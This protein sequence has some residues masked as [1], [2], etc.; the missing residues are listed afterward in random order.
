MRTTSKT[1][2]KPALAAA[3]AALLATTTAWGD[4]AAALQASQLVGTWTLVAADV[5]RPD[6]TRVHDYGDAPHGSLIVAANGTYSVQIYSS[7]RPRFAAGDKAKGTDAEF[8]Q[9]ILGCSTHYGRISVDPAAHVMTLD[10]Q[11]SS[12]P[13]QEGLP[14][15][16]QYELKDDVLSYR[17]A[18]RPDGS[19]PVSQWRRVR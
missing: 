10:V 13:N 5:L 1:L 2:N 7:E 9:A 16:R 6:G 15:K 11:Q 19:I 3:F 8:R 17:V 14:Q 12:Y 4:D 18:A